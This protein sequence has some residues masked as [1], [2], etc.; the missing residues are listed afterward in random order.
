MSQNTDAITIYNTCQ[1]YKFGDNRLCG[2][3]VA[4]GD[5]IK[6]CGRHTIEKQKAHDK[7]KKRKAESSDSEEDK[8]SNTA[9]ALKAL[10]GTDLSDKQK[11]FLKEKL[12]LLE[13]H[14]AWCDQVWNETAETSTKALVDEM[15]T[16]QVSEKAGKEEEEEEEGEEDDDDGDEEEE[17]G[18]EEEEDGNEEE[19]EPKPDYDNYGMYD[20]PDE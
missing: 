2:K 12:E 11:H 19:E 13:Q 16:C 8:E 9:E 6:F 1:F 15:A 20:Q 14:D 17:D 5:G 18:D 3:S 10:M 4:G 7:K